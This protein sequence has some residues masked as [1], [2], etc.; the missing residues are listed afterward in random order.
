MIGYT[1]ADAGFVVVGLDIEWA[2][3]IQ[4]SVVRF[5]EGSIRI[6]TLDH[7]LL[8]GMIVDTH[9]GDVWS[10]IPILVS[11][12]SGS[13]AII[14]VKASEEVQLLLS[15]HLVDLREDVI[16]RLQ[17]VCHGATGNIGIVEW[18]TVLIFV[19]SRVCLIVFGDAVG[20]GQMCIDDI[21]SD[22]PVPS[23]Q[24]EISRDDGKGSA[25]ISV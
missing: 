14:V 19:V 25:H 2:I 24:L 23:L 11:I 21:A 18:V 16:S 20:I 10:T 17:A 6:F 3:T 13:H 4:S 12:G 22:Y 7:N 9:G 1:Q 15:L 8:D 5:P